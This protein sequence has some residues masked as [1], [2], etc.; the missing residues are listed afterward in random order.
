M[1]CLTNISS[2]NRMVRDLIDNMI[3]PTIRDLLNAQDPPTPYP[4]LE[5]VIMVYGN[6]V[7]EEIEFRDNVIS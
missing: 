1:W 2:G 6:I 5:Q 3:L 7:S 4:I